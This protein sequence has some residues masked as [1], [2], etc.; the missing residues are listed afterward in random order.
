MCSLF[1]NQVV[2][3]CFLHLKSH[4][5]ILFCCLQTQEFGLTKQSEHHFHLKNFLFQNTEQEFALLPQFLFLPDLKSDA[6]ALKDFF[7]EQIILCTLN[8]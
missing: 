6:T 4:P 3:I 5:S 2:S 7:R 1:L 8:Q